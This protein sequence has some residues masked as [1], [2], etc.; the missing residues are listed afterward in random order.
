MADKNLV[1]CG[2]GKMGGALLNGWLSNGFDVERIYVFEPN[3]AN[4]L[5]SLARKGLNLNREPS[6]NPHICVMAVKPNMIE[7][8]LDQKWFGCLS[9][10]LF[11]SVVAGVK[12]K[13]LNKLL[14]SKAS[15]VRI[16][17][18]TPATIAKGVSCL[19]PNKYTS[20]QQLKLAETLFAA[21]GHTIRL[22]SEKQMDVVTAI[23]GS[24]PAYVFYLIEVLTKAGIDLGL[25]QR[26]ASRLAVLTVSG[27]GMLAEDSNLAVSKLRENV[28]SPNGTTEAALRV[29]MHNK[30]GLLPLMKETI[31][32]AYLRSKELG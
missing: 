12:L 24:G 8:L 9:N 32:A 27:S 15:V 29:L 3:P 21:V 22:S 18:N 7:E 17:P 20:E 25:N 30:T 10:T 28:T 19:I 23:S 4:W 6:I 31:S 16:M 14:D 13:T 26:L 11:V 1:L 2:A 5:V